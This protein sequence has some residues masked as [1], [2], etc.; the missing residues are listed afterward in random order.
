MKILSIIALLAL[1]GCA[2]SIKEVNTDGR[3]PECVRECTKA[4]SGCVSAPQIGFKTETLRACRDSYSV[5][6]DTCE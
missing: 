5:C 6:V 4:Y 1:T 3:E 2:Y